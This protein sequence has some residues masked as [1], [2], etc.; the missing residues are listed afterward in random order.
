MK[1][2][3]Q[4]PHIFQEPAPLG[5]RH[6]QCV[7]KGYQLLSRAP[8]RVCVRSVKTKQSTEYRLLNFAK[9]L[10]TRS[11]GWP[12]KQQAHLGRGGSAPSPAEGV[13]RGHCQGRIAG[14]LPNVEMFASGAVGARRRGGARPDS[15]QA[16]EDQGDRSPSLPSPHHS[17]PN[18]SPGARD[19][20][21]KREPAKQGEFGRRPFLS[22][23][24]PP[25]TDLLCD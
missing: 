1:R 13:T 14:R 24:P 12:R 19:P 7:N 8:E 21:L 16:Q 23:P 18:T 6:G 9:C 25:A 20:S 17:F 2:E 10:D 15:K 4:S 22:L 3:A 11:Q 5:G